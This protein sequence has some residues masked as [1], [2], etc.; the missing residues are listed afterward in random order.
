MLIPNF[1]M[2][3]QPVPI[4]VFRVIEWGGGWAVGPQYFEEGSVSLQMLVRNKIAFQ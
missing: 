4:K 3:N 2:F 1:S